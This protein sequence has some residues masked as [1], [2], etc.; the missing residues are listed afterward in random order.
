[1]RYTIKV[2]EI[3]TKAKLLQEARSVLPNS[4]KTKIVVT[5]NFREWRHFFKLRCAFTAHPQMRQVTIPLLLCFKEY[6]S[7]IF[8]DIAYD[9]NFLIKNYAEVVLTDELFK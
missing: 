2:C 8:G 5:F 3:D 6:L 7:P 4:L 9:T 1:M